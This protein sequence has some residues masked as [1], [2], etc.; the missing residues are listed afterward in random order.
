MDLFLYCLGRVEKTIYSPFRRSYFQLEFYDK[1][2]KIA[3][4]KSIALDFRLNLAFSFQP[5]SENISFIENTNLTKYNS[6]CICTEWMNAFLQSSFE[7]LLN[8]TLIVRRTDTFCP[9]FSVSLSRLR[10]RDGHRCRNPNP[11]YVDRLTH[12]AF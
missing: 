6:Q 2:K 11:S 12:M 4:I 3:T 5:N 9:T 8:W 7:T 10:I 1:S